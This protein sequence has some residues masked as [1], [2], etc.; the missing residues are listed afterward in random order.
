MQMLYDTVRTR[1]LALCDIAPDVKRPAA[2]NVWVKNLLFIAFSIHEVS[3]NGPQFLIV[4]FK[5]SICKNNFGS[6]KVSLSL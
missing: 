5:C 6:G 3:D 1:E 4:L 2:V